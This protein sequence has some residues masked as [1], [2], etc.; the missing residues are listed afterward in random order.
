VEKEAIA[1]ARE[2]LGA[3]I[4]GLG[5]KLTTQTR[6]AIADADDR[7]RHQ[8]LTQVRE[9]AAQGLAERRTVQEIASRLREVTGD[10]GRAW[11]Q[12]AQ[13]EVHSAIEEG[14]ANAILSSLPRG[15]DPLVYKRVHP[16]ACPFC[17]L[18]YLDG[19][20]PRVFRLSELSA[21]GTN[22]GRRAK[23][24]THS[25]P[26]A[27]E[28]KATLGAVHPW[29]RCTLHHLREGFAFDAEGQ[30]HYVGVK[31]SLEQVQRLNVALLDHA[32]EHE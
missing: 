5:D 8:I 32:C 27:T 6:I 7:A 14:K 24:P 9:T 1:V 21:N 2:R 3:H 30:L 15:E 31:K 10:N 11:K 25:G 26:S 20:K 29:C 17:R 18:L 19:K 16:E 12:L 28:W 22:T 23:R 13:T 4:Q